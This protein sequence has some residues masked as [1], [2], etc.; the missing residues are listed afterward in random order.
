MRKRILITGE[1]SYIGKSLQEYVSKEKIDWQIDAVSVRDDQWRNLD[2][3]KYQIIIHLAA[4]VHQ[5]EQ[6]EMRNLYKK[7]N[8]RLPIEIARQAKAQGV[9]QFVFLS[10]MAVYG[11]K[12]SVISADTKVQPVTMYGKAKLAA[13]KKLKQLS[14]NGFQVIVLRPPLVYGRNCPGNYGRL[15]SLALKLPIFPKVEN[16]RSMIYIENL[17]ACICNYVEKSDKQYEIVCPQNIDYV[18]TTELVKEIRKAHGKK[19]WLVPFGGGI[20]SFLA[21]RVSVFH[22]VFGDLVYEKSQEDKEYQAVGFE[23]SVRRTEQ[24]EKEMENCQTK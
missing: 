5:K 14:D 16:R 17:C 9:G 7:V 11:E 13:E 23:E 19:T 22:K 20:I 12:V 15:A 4:V 10:T 3:K 21:A 24:V 1:N 8:A 2:Y 18:N 6:P